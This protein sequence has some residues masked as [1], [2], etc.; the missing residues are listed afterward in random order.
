MIDQLITL[1]KR[2]QDPS[3]KISFPATP[4]AWEGLLQEAERNGLDSY[5]YHLLKTHGLLAQVPAE[6][7]DLLR[8]KFIDSS[9]THFK[10]RKVLK[11][12]LQR[13][14]QMNIPVIVLKGG[15]LA[16]VVYA[17]PGLR[18]MGDLD[19]LV[20]CDYLAPAAA[21]LEHL[22]YQTLDIN[23]ARDGWEL[24]HHLPVFHH[25]QHIPVELHWRIER[26]NIKLDITFDDLAQQAMP[27]E[28][29]G[30][31]AYAPGVV[32]CLLHLCTHWGQHH[33]FLAGLRPAVDVAEY[34]RHY[35]SELDWDLFFA[36][37]DRWGVSPIVDLCL[38]TADEL[39][40]C[41]LPA[42]VRSR[43]Q[44][45]RTDSE[46]RH[47]A[48]ELTKSRPEVL[49]RYPVNLQ[50]L[51]VRSSLRGR[52]QQAVGR[53]FPSRG[54][55]SFYYPVS[56][57][58]PKIF[59]YYPARWWHLISTYSGRVFNHYRPDHTPDADQMEAERISRLQI[60]LA[61]R[62]GLPLRLS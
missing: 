43:W 51:F 14:E 12:I 53:F 54:E 15:Y 7:I 27:F 18:G 59:G 8:G 31:K 9:L 26:P 25:R 22:G 56:A 61:G 2:L 3:D 20:H 23:R 35:E 5:L 58:S 21:A 44:S 13:F 30:Q 29:N 62:F 49:V 11:D 46:L 16:E 34:V 17:Q 60:R 38:Q 28:M 10:N 1:L 37:A 6:I 32:D 50:N 45:N 4:A 57:H 36:T 42:Q 47:L 48:V 41:R 24:F 19:I 55:M 52:V 39:I 40:G 33:L